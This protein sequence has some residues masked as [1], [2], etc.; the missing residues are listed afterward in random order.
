M[1]GEGLGQRDQAGQRARIPFAEPGHE[2]RQVLGRRGRAGR[3]I[4][5]PHD[6][7]DHALQAHGP[8]VVGRE[9]ARDAVVVQ[10]RDLVRQDR[11]AAAGKDEDAPSG[12]R[13]QIVHVLEELEVPALVARD[14]DALHVLLHGAVDDLAHRAVVPEV[15][16]LGAGRLQEATH[17]VDRGVVAVE[18]RGRRDQA[19][20]MDGTIGLTA[21]GGG[22]RRARRRAGHRDLP[23]GA[24][25]RQ[26][27]GQGR[28]RK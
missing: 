6:L 27:A 14:G 25:R 7:V 9:H 18:Q 2:R 19:D 8:S 10:L 28:R 16:D 20:V 24:M 1:V 11:A 15:D 3:E 5:L 22:R 26:R 12:S 4:A 21:G 23:E 17:D 13:D